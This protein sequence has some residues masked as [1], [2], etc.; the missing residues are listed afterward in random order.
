MDLSR[1]HSDALA[2][3]FQD[4]SLRRTYAVS[5]ALRTGAQAL[6]GYRAHRIFRPNKQN[7]LPLAT[8]GLGTGFK[9]ER[10]IPGRPGPGKPCVDYP[11]PNRTVKRS[12]VLCQQIMI[13][14]MNGQFGSTTQ[15]AA[16]AR[17]GLCGAT[18]A[19]RRLCGTGLRPGI[20]LSGCCSDNPHTN[21][22][23][24]FISHHLCVCTDRAVCIFA[25][26]GPRCSRV[27]AN[28]CTRG[29]L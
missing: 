16:D 22:F 8:V 7:P 12:G 4:L 14:L 15:R 18:L 2:P 27:Q 24:Q 3:S 6:P 17:V 9:Y 5:C 21:S 23:C 28:S 11:F 26:F 29:D 25:C 19:T 13:T 1:T 10:M 20:P